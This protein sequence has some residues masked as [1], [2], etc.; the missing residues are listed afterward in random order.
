MEIILSPNFGYA[1]LVGIG[2]VVALIVSLL[3]RAESKWL[4]VKHTVQWYMTAGGTVKKG[5]LGSSI[6]SAWVWAATLLESS[7][8]TYQYG[9]GGA[10]WYAA[11][12]TIPLIL[13]SILAFEVKRKTNN[14]YTFAQIIDNRFGAKA[15]KLFLFF[16][17]LTNTI[18]ASMLVLG[19]AAAIHALTGIDIYIVCMLLPVGI[20]IYTFV[21]GLRATFF[22]DYLNV[23]VLFTGLIIFVSLVYFYNPQIGGISGMYERLV[24]AAALRPVAG[25]AFGSYLTLASTGAL[26]FGV[27]NIV[28]NF[29]TVFVDQTYWQR[30]IAAKKTDAAAGFIIGGLAWFAIPFTLASTLGIAAVATGIQL[31]PEQVNLGLVAAY[32]AHSLFG[33][34]G[35]IMIIVM[36]FSAV[37]AAGSA[38]LIAS[39]SLITHDIYK[40]YKNP[41]APSH[42]LF[43]TMRKIVVFLGLGMTL[44]GMLL[45]QFGL[46]L[47]YVYLI[48]GILIGPAVGPIALALL[49]EKTN[50]GAA[51]LAA[52]SGLICGV[53]VW[54]G[55]SSLTGPLSIQSTSQN[56]PLLFGNLASLAIGFVITVLGS[57]VK[58]ENFNW[59]QHEQ[60]ATLFDFKKIR[61]I[62]IS[63]SGVLVILWPLPLYLSDFVFTEVVFQIWILL[64]T[65]WSSC[66]ASV[67]IG[68]PIFESRDSILE[69]VKRSAIPLIF[70]GIIFTIIFSYGFISSPELKTKYIDAFIFFTI[71]VLVGFGLVV[72]VLNKKLSVLVRLQTN[73]IKNERD[74]LQQIVK[75]RTEQLLRQEKLV[76]IG[77]LAA[78]ISH[79]LRNPLAVITLNL[80]ILLR[81]AAT[82]LQ[83]DRCQRMLRASQ[84]IEQQ[85]GEVMSFIRTYPS[86]M[87]EVSLSDIIDSMLERI[88][89]PPTISITKDI[90]DV[91]LVCNETQ[92]ES[93]L[94]NLILNA[95]DAVNRNG[96]ILIRAVEYKNFVVID[97]KD[98]GPPIPPDI[99]S[100]MFEPLF[101]TKISGTGLGLASCKQIV[102]QHRGTISVRTTP[103]V[104]TIR[105]PKN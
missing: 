37:T 35:A 69:I 87:R 44:L 77:E 89:I 99:L 60:F 19:G 29:G 104:F 71:V 90:A 36:I 81:D 88:S 101:T 48:M 6:V 105:L 22:A 45:F 15:H 28:G 50:R 56:M 33:E 96:E 12:A 80:G 53:S 75:E 3:I 72:L 76:M 32:S 55:L 16:A 21:G 92:I 52:I 91:S 30:T 47:Q 51:M 27:I 65:V 49:W 39:A 98:S 4:G 59:R 43:S 8:V 46:N 57:I 31:S 17:L 41:S 62:S 13:F 61:N 34:I 18:V 5:L 9:I 24:D 10:F 95:I 25:N 40:R 7:T 84:K 23:V 63:I 94:T 54:L 70:S 11:G 93:A 2:I 26:V 14:V 83:M 100:R 85:V 103:T 1:I 97:V 20:V 42:L 58:P 68:L 78:R 64:A 82:P 67:V 66:A 102:E 38:Q 74:H 73:E 86:K 79:D